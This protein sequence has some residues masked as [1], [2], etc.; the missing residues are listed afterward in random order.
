[1]IEID[2]K[3]YKFNMPMT[4]HNAKYNS[5]IIYYRNTLEH[6][7]ELNKELMEYKKTIIEWRN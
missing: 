4:P 2:G 6:I 1:M 5:A 7:K 3:K